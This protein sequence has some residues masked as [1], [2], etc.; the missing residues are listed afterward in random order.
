MK[1][2]Q[3]VNRENAAYWLAYHFTTHNCNAAS[4][5]IIELLWGKDKKLN[6]E[7]DDYDFNEVIKKPTTTFEFFALAKSLSE[8]MR[9]S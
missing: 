8:K 2:T 3:G 9:S 1:R 5:I 6:D 4:S 7:K